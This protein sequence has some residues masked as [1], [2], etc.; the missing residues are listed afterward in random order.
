MPDTCTQHLELNNTVIRIEERLI[1][2]NEKVDEALTFF[3]EHVKSSV[4]VR[5]CVKTNTGFRKS[6]Q[7]GIGVLYAATIGVAIRTLLK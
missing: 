2:Q 5:D 6:A 1:A 7:W 4:S 3:R